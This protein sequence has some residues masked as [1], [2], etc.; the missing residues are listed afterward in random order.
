[1][2]A[3]FFDSSSLVK[4]FANEIG[5]LRVISLFRGARPTAYYA[6]R[7]TFVEVSSSIARK[8]RD[9]EIKVD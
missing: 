6:A 7:I 3:Y 2:A 5:T 8:V 9:G 4:R 1:M